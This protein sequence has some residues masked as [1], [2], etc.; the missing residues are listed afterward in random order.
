MFEYLKFNAY[1]SEWGNY[2][3]FISSFALWPMTCG[4][5]CFPFLGYIGSCL[6]KS[7]VYYL[8][9]K[10][11]LGGSR[12]QKSGLWSLI[13]HCLMWCLWRERNSSIFEDGDRSIL[14]LRL[15]FLRTLFDWMS[16]SR[17]FSFHTF[18]DFLD[19][20]H[21]RTWLYAAMNSHLVRL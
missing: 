2:W 9:G 10:A 19:H 21:F 13:P 11:V 4:P 8:A 12:I 7:S 15:Q 5:L 14:D 17:L 6:E 16:A 3:S 18:L 20:C 1:F